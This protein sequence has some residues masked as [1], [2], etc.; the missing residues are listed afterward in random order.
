MTHPNQI[1]GGYGECMAARHLVEQGMAVLDRNWRGAAGEID[2][3]AR[4]GDDLR[5]RQPA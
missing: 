4:D 2:L 5:P 1:I 3:I